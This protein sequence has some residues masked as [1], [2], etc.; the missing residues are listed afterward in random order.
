MTQKVPNA[1]LVPPFSAPF[2]LLVDLAT[3]SVDASLANNFYLTLTA[4]GHAM[5]APTN[6]TDGQVC[7]FIVSSGTGGFTFTWNAVFNFGGAGAPTHS[8]IA[9]KFDLVSAIYSSVAG[10]WICSFRKGS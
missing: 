10:A 5:G 9:A 2:V 3:V 6:A 1:L 8:T 7:N 4:S